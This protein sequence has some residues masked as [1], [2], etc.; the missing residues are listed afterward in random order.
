MTLKHAVESITVFSLLV[1]GCGSNARIAGTVTDTG[2]PTITGRIV[3]SL[4][5]S[6]SGV[7]A[8]A[9]PQGYDPVADRAVPDSMKD[10]TD[11]T[12]RFVIRVPMNGMY[13]VQALHLMLGTRLLIE[14]INA[15]GDRTVLPADTMRKPARITVIV[16][17]GFD[18][19]NGYFFV[20]GTTIYGLLSNAAASVVLDSV[21]ALTDLSIYYGVRGGSAQPQPVRDSVVVAPGGVMNIEYVGWTFSRNLALNTTASGAN[22]AGNVMDFPVLIRLTNA[23]FNFAEAKSAGEDV[24]FTKSDGTSLSYEIERWD[25]SAQAAEVW[26]KLDT[27]YGS[28]SAH[29]ITMYWG[30]ASATSASNSATVF[31]TVNGFQ[32]VWHLNE[33]GTTAAKEATQNHYDGTKVGMTTASRVTGMIGGAQ[34]FD[35]ASSYITIP[36]SDTGK[37]NFPEKGTYSLSAWVNAD[38]LR[39]EVIIENGDT[40]PSNYCLR[41]SPAQQYEFYEYSTAPQGWDTRLA[42]ASANSWKFVVGVRAGTK[43]Y[44]Y[45]DGQCIDSVGVFLNDVLK[46]TKGGGVAIGRN[47]VWNI[48]YFKGMIDEVCMANV[49]RSPDWI[50]LC[51]MNQK[52]KDALVEF[53]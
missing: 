31:D 36:N 4:G 34:K 38:T 3:D 40:T 39:Q 50:K 32:G 22:V 10:T 6:V 35:G 14:N 7:Q 53:K 19:T 24:R 30:N 17:A 16:P 23:N 26:V 43:G 15:A 1:L 13:N 44:M 42:N 52:S 28:D 49:S 37:L 27:I 51:Y 48:N 20:P 29:F 46:R 47:Y 33:A 18:K 8:F 41:I 5:Y 11:E 21:P 25:A 45:V 2:N 9:I 12:G